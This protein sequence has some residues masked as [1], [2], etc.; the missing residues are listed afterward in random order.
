[1][2]SNNIW[3]TIK[4]LKNTPKK[5]S[6]SEMITNINT[7]ENKNK[8]FTIKIPSK[9]GYLPETSQIKYMRPIKS[10]PNYLGSSIVKKV[11]EP[12]LLLNE[13]EP[14]LKSINYSNNTILNLTPVVWI[15]SSNYTSLILDSN[16]N[17]SQILDKSGN[18]NHMYQN[19]IDNQPKYHNGGLLFNGNQYLTGNNTFTQSI[20]NMSIVIVMKQYNQ[21]NQWGGII[22][23]YSEN[24][25]NDL[26]DP[27]AWVFNSS[28]FIDYQ[29]LFSSNQNVNGNMVNINNINQTMLYGVYEIIINNNSGYIYYNGNLITTGNFTELGTFTNIVLGARFQGSNIFDKFYTGEIYETII[30]NSALGPDA[31]YSVEKL[32][33]DKWNPVQISRTIPLNNVYTWLDASSPNNF[34]LDSNNNVLSWNDKN[35]NLNFTQSNPSFYPKFDTNKVIFN[36]S[37]LTMTDNV[38]LDLNNFS[39]FYVVEELEHTDYTGLLSGINTTGENDWQV[40]DGFA[41]T[42]NQPGG[43]GLEINYNTLNYSS[44]N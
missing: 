36:N 29:Y 38:G 40:T 3:D 44:N 15:D 19:I 23:G 41:L 27:N 25:A 28:D 21:T 18:N 32:L 10:I 22:S 33:L 39:I 43:I 11:V 24:S 30:F 14:K 26:F 34:T 17:V 13:I 20:N 31:R 6:V 8:I 4:E 7:K 12:K 37:Y 16:N 2:N 35:F 9:N 1:M 42:T 5:L